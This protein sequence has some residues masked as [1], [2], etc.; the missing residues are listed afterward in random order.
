M[1]QMIC[2]NCGSTGRPKTETKGSILI[3]IILWL[4]FIVPGLI[5][6][7]W[8]MSTRSKVC[9]SCGARSLVPLD[10]PRGKQLVH[11]L[12]QHGAAAQE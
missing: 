10:S 12:S 2:N 9:R 4:S 6:S 11:Q 8:R 7:I 1:A 3:E 5:Y